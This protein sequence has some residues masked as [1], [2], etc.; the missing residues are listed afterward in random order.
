MNRHILLA[1]ADLTHGIGEESDPYLKVFLLSD[2]AGSV[3]ESGIAVSQ[4]ATFT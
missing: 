2:F 4:G 1:L 3:Y